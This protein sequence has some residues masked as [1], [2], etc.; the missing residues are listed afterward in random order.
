M[1]TIMKYD[2]PAAEWHEAFPLGNGRLGAVVFGGACH[3]RIEL[4]EDTLWSGCPVKHPSGADPDMIRKAA[5][6][7]RNRNYDEATGLLRDMLRKAAANQL[8]HPFGTVH[9][10][11]SD[12]TPADRYERTLDLSSAVMTYTCTGKDRRLR[13]T[14]FADAVSDVIVYHLEADIPFA[15][16]IFAEGPLIRGISAEPSD[17]P[18][19]AQLVLKGQC[20][21]NL[22][23]RDLKDDCTFDPRPKTYGDLRFPDDPK[24]QGMPFEGRVFVRLKDGRITLESDAVVCEKTTELTLFIGIRTAFNGYDRHPVTDGRD[25]SALLDR[26]MAASGEDWT[27]LME[28]HIADY[29]R[30]FDRVEL[31]LEKNGGGENLPDLQERL[32]ACQKE[33]ADPALCELLFHYGRYL[34]ICCSRPGTQPANLQG[35]WNRDLI[36]AWHSGYTTNINLQMNYWMTGVCAMPELCEPLLAMSEELLVTGGRTAEELMGKKGSVCFHNSDIWRKADPSPGLALWGYWY[37]GGAWICRNLYENYLFAPDEELLKRLLPVLRENAR[38][39]YDMLEQADDGCILPAATSPENSFLWNEKDYVSVG[40]YSENVMAIARGLFRDYTDAC[41]RAGDTDGLYES[42]KDVLPRLAPTQIGSSGQI[43]EWNE[44]FAETDPH[45]RHLSHLYDFHPGCG[46]TVHTPRLYEAVWQSLLLRGDEGTGWSMAWKLMM[47]ARL[48]DGARAE[49]IIQR[50]FHLVSGNAVLGLHGGGLYANL[51][52]AHPPFQID[53]NLGYTA[54]VAELL[55]QSHDG[56]LV[57]LP[58][59]PPSWTAGQFSGLRARGGI[60]VDCR[61][62]GRQASAALTADRDVTVH[63]VAGNWKA[64]ELL[65]KKGTAHRFAFVF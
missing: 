62:E 13:Q 1:H 10:D 33:G 27:A 59:L 53:G 54:A 26:D 45:H 57:L 4:N 31:T 34:L 18:L 14:A 20:P 65:L 16:R 19:A 5:K 51:F 64:T 35:I 6:A 7:A 11:F 46:I 42:I 22:D 12:K 56:R 60:S 24:E 55:V 58:A 9:L 8:Y 47:W 37:M 40:L 36:P 41:E 50:L 30:Y 63:L 2:H 43:L 29:R 52:C 49:A 15:V 23:L 3:E 32:A 39:C 25:P 48:G 21:G 38:F 44:E 61:W 17:S 28:A